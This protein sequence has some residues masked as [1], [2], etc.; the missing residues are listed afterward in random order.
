MRIPVVVEMSDLGA[1]AS[2]EPPLERQPG[3][4]HYERE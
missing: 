4:S 1:Q 3:W 2:L